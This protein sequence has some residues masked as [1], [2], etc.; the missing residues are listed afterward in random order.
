M[1]PSR[2]VFGLVP[3]EELGPGHAGLSALV[4]WLGDKTGLVVEWHEAGSYETLAR[5]VQEGEVGVAWLPPILFVHLEREGVVV[6]LVANERLELGFV[7]AL[8]VAAE[9]K[10]ESLEDLRGSRVAWV[11]PLSA[12]GYV[13]PRLELAARGL[14]P[15]ALFRSETFLRSHVAAVRAVAEGSADVAA[16]FARLNAVGTV[17]RGGWTDAGLSQ[18]K[19]RILFASKPLPP[20]LIAV[21]SD[22][23]AEVQGQL[24]VAFVELSGD[25]GMRTIA[26]R[27]LGVDAFAPTVGASYDGLRATIEAAASSGLV[28]VAARYVSRPPP[29]MPSSIPP[30]PS[31]PPSTS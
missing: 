11:D 10:L 22:V 4:R 29:S 18:R 23:S 9:S 30:P 24:S 2:L 15:R 14:E 27:L 1:D 8:V 5:S 25:S 16:T 7:A 3:R 26:K 19:F 21:R 20:D 31:K 13:V 17:T 12:T 28:E 6:P